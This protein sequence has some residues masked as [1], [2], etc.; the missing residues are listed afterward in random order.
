VELLRKLGVL[1]PEVRFD[2]GRLLLPDGSAVDA[3]LSLPCVRA[4]LGERGLGRRLRGGVVAHA[5]FRIPD[6]FR[7]N[8]P[9][10]G[11]VLGHALKGLGESLAR[12]RPPWPRWRGLAKV[13]SPPRAARPYLERLGLERPAGVKERLLRRAVVYALVAD[14]AV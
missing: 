10:R 4:W 1:R 7:A 2:D 3:D 5:G 13:A 8:L 12:R 6:R 11:V 14:G 9:E